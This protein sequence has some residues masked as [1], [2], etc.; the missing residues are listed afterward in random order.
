MSASAR[1][2]TAMGV[3]AVLGD[4]LR[5]LKIPRIAGGQ[6]LLIEREASR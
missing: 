6:L 4:W 2:W 5:A 1:P 3:H